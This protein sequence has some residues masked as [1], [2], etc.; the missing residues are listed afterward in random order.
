MLLRDS[1][2]PETPAGLAETK[3]DAP[4]VVD[5][6]AGVVDE[7]EGMNEEIPEVV[8]AP[9]RTGKGKNVDLGLSTDVKLKSPEEHVCISVHSHTVTERVGD[10][11]FQ[12]GHPEFNLPILTS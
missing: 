1:L 11:I 8:I 12:V 7:E 9:K 4:V 10:I 5:A 2:V 3:K 6:Q